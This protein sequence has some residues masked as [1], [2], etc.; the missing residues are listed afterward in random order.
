MKSILLFLILVLSAHSFA[1]NKSILILGDSLSA[2]Y[3]IDVQ[4]SWPALLQT[5]LKNSGQTY[6]IHN[7]SISGQTSAEG[8]SQMDQLLTLAKPNI[9]ILELG[10]NDGLRGLSI[11]AMQKNLQ[12]MIDKSRTAKAKVLLIGI[13]TPTN[14]GRRYGMMFENSFQN[15]AKQNELAFIPFMLEPIANV[16]TSTN[17]SEYIQDDGLH[18]TAKAQPLLMNYIYKKLQPLL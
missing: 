11:K 16:I 4:D 15:L 1:D 9:V 7:A 13:R 12:S 6:T 5:Q 14:Y 2:G 10:A 3:G 18:P 17:R 8:I